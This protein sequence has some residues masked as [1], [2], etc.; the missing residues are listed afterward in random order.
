METLRAGELGRDLEELRGDA[1]R[2]ID[3]RMGVVIEARWG[4]G[5]GGGG[6]GRIH[7]RSLNIEISYFRVSCRIIP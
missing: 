6:D 5:G 3:C 2:R 4:G 1:L 7:P